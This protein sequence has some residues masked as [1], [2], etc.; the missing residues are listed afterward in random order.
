MQGVLLAESAILVTFESVGSIF[1]VFESVVV[2]LFAFR[3]SQHYLDSVSFLRCHNLSPVCVAKVILRTQKITPLIEVQDYDNIPKGICQTKKSNYA[4][5]V[6]SAMPLC[7]DKRAL[8]HAGE[9]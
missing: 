1:A 8:P 9:K 4:K 6:N 3:A 5:K 2:A 7:A